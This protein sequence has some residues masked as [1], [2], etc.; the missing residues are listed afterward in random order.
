MYVSLPSPA[1]PCLSLTKIDF[2]SWAPFGRA[3]VRTLLLFISVMIVFILRVSHLKFGQRTAVSPLAQ[4]TYQARSTILL[5]TLCFYLISG[6]WFIEVYIWSASASAD[7]KWVKADEEI[8]RDQ[9]NERPIFLRSIAGSLALAMTVIHL[10]KDYD[11]I[12]IDH[13]PMLDGPKKAPSQRTAIEIMSTRFQSSLKTVLWTTGIVT[14]A[15]LIL[16]PWF[17]RSFAWAW[18]LWI[19]RFIWDIPRSASLPDV[20]P[21]HYTLLVRLLSASF[22]LVS[23]W[24]LSNVAFGAWVCQPPVKHNQPLTSGSRDPN[25]SLINGLKTKNSLTKVSKQLSEGIMVY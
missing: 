5:R 12:E 2:W 15:N 10:Y 7:L 11:R 8:G 18:S 23:L 21:Y 1:Y 25:A 13:Y 14:I 6:C 19:G 24:E 9:L 17:L 16:Y 4:F 22:F 3:G 20:P